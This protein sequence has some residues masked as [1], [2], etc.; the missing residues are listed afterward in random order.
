MPAPRW[1]SIRASL[2][3]PWVA[4][5][6]FERATTWLHFALPLALGVLMVMLARRFVRPRKTRHFAV[7]PLALG[8]L[9]SLWLVK[10]SYRPIQASTSDVLYFH[11]VVASYQEQLHVTAAAPRIR[12]QRRRTLTVPR[13]TRAPTP[14]R[15][16]L[17]ILQESQRFD[18]TCTEFDPDCPAA[19]RASNPLVPSRVP[20]LRWHSLGSSTSL[21]CMTLWTGMLPSDPLP[22]LESAPTIFRYA[23]AAGFHPIY[24]TSQYLAAFQNMRLQFQNEPIERFVHASHLNMKADWDTGAS[25]MAL[26]D[27]AS[28]HWS[29]LPEPF[30]A[31]VHYANQHQPY[32]EDPD[33]APFAYDPS[34]SYESRE[35]QL[36][37]NRNV[38][39]LSDLAVARF[40]EAVKHSETG[41]RTVI[42]YTSDHGEGMGEHGWSGHT[43]THFETEIHVPTWLDAPPDTLTDAERTH[44]GERKLAW[45]THADVTP[46]FLD[47]LGV[48]DAPELASF[49]AHM[50]GVPLT[51]PLEPPKPLPLTNDSWI[52]EST[53]R[54]WGYMHGNLK[55]MALDG[56]EALRCYDLDVDPEER[57]DLGEERCGEL[58]RLT[59]ALFPSAASAQHPFHPLR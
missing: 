5:L 41:Q 16:V 48:W 12:P 3:W 21:S 32:V 23:E 47:L 7:V 22:Q 30:F 40:L 18:V 6:P 52:W 50:M 49:R 34:K 26:S 8:A 37:R 11:G 10:S 51:R 13:L 35:N 45:L 33:R 57:L 28:A 36:V 29:E 19:T 59:R 42:L 39:Y 25:D 20:F 56:S 2:L 14:R 17:L 38:V 54:S 27:Y 15:N 24:L 53:H 43:V 55:A 44:V 9:A 4:S 1:T 46:T 58:P 31:I